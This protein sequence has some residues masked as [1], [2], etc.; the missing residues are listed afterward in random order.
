MERRNFIKSG[1]TFC[2][3]AA[4]GMLLPMLEGCGTTQKT[5]VYKTTVS[6]N[7]IEIPVSLFADKKIQ[8]VRAKGQYYDIAVQQHE[9]K[10]YTALLMRCT[11]MDNQLNLSGNGYRCSLHGSEFDNEGNGKKG[12]A[13]HALKKY[14]VT[15]NNDK[16]IITI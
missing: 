8:I 16:L 1:C 11:H 9:D 10:T 12:P 6:G 7:K 3:L 13:E 14:P 2:L 15:I 4:G 5:S